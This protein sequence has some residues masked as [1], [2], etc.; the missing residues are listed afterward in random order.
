[1]DLCPARELARY[2]LFGIVAT[3]GMDLVNFIASSA[4]VIGKL[5]LVFIGNLVNQWGQGQFLFLRPGDIPQVPHA[6]LLGYGAH[7]F[8][9]I[10]LALLFYYFIFSVY[11]PRRGALCRAVIYGLVCSLISL[12]LIYPSVGL[13]FFGSAASGSGLLVSSLVNHAVYGLVLGICG[14]WPRRQAVCVLH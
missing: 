14:I 8:A 12:C 13:G 5:N 1:M 9:G 7:Y 3:L 10:V 6:L 11:H 2:G 4:G